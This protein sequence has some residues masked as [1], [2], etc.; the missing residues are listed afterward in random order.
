MGNT[1]ST[2]SRPPSA[3][4]SSVFNLSE[5]RRPRKGLSATLHAYPRRSIFAPDED[6]PD[7]FTNTPHDGVLVGWTQTEQGFVIPQIR[8]LPTSIPLDDTI[9]NSPRPLPWVER[10]KRSRSPVPSARSIPRM[11]QF[12]IESMRSIRRELRVVNDSRP[13]SAWSLDE[14]RRELRVV[15]GSRPASAGSLCEGRGNGR[16]SSIEDREY[17]SDS[18]S[19]SWHER[20]DVNVEDEVEYVQGEKQSLKRNDSAHDSGYS[21]MAADAM[22]D[23]TES[24]EPYGWEEAAGYISPNE[25]KLS[26]YSPT[27]KSPTL[28]TS[29]KSPPMSPA[30]S[31]T[32]PQEVVQ[33]L[34]DERQES[35]YISQILKKHPFDEWTEWRTTL[36]DLL[37]IPEEEEPQISSTPVMRPV[38]P[39]P[40]PSIPPEPRSPSRRKSLF[41]FAK[42]I[43][44]KNVLNKR[45]SVLW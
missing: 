42:V 27:I 15:N 2:P 6:E 4:A 28:N 39:P 20:P 19:G 37:M 14:G 16:W 35:A 31:T 30:L 18:D 12:S 9:F 17:D 25:A 11:R 13:G 24:I 3:S 36:T 29:F 44:T 45:K 7:D 38:T 41:N 5:P 34:N 22:S 40:P 10:E 21:T 26:C 43:S 8:S 33:Y 1:F 23:S 32:M